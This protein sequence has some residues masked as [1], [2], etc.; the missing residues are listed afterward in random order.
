LRQPGKNGRLQYKNSEIWATTEEHWAKLE[1]ICWE[2]GG[3]GL[4]AEDRIKQLDRLL[5]DVTLT[6]QMRCA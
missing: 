2:L 6:C 5:H 1:E 4:K 3:L